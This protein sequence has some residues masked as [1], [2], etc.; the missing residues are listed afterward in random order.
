MPP[1]GPRALDRAMEREA[2]RARSRPATKPGRTASK[3][4][5]R[6][7]GEETP[8]ASFDAVVAFHADWV[9]SD[10]FLPANTINNS[11]RGAMLARGLVTEA[12][13]KAR[14]VR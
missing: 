11:L 14:G 9:N 10:R 4:T 7:K 5:K 13:L 1:D 8:R 6:R 12:R 3:P 2:R